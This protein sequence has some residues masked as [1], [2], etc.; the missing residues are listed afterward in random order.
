VKELNKTVQ[1]LK[2]EL[3]IIKKLQRERTLQIKI[4]GKNTG[5][6]DASV[7]NRMQDILELISGTEDATG[8]IDQQSKKMQNAK[9]PNTKHPGNPGHNEKTEPK[10]KKIPNLKGQ[11]WRR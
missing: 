5:V 7:T 10:D 9:A 11:C 3:G 6:I 8:N 1:D 4:L 2:L